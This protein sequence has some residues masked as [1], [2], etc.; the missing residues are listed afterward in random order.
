VTT[1]NPRVQDLIATL[2]LI[3][4]PEGGYY[5]ELYRSSTSVLPADGRGERAAL[6]TIYFLLPAG[7]VSRWHRVQSDEVWH[8]YEGAAL[9][10]WTASPDGGKA[11]RHRLG[12]LD[13]EQR[14][15]ETVR[16]GWWQAARSTGDYSL[17]GCTVGPGFDFRDFVLA[18]DRPDYAAA[19]R[20]QLPELTSLL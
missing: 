6:T 15:A 5:G 19:L 16:A 20:T 8:F 1:V 17:V 10:L 7:A 3:S 12:P 2:G 14:P 4:H 13:G 9:D 18:G 11:S